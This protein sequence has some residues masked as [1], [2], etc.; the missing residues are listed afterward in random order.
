MS[1]KLAASIIPGNVDAPFSKRL[2]GIFL[3][4]I[5]T[6]IYGGLL[7]NPGSSI[8]HYCGMRRDILDALKKAK[9]S[10]V[11]L[12]GGDY[13]D[14]Y[15]W[16]NGI[17]EKR[18]VTWNANWRM[19]DPNRFGTH[20]FMALCEYLGAEPYFV[21]NLG[22]GTVE[23]ARAWVEYCNHPSGTVYSEMRIK[24]GHEKPFGVKLWGVGNEP[25]NR[26]GFMTPEYYASVYRNHA[27]FMRL[28]DPTVE[29][30]M[31]GSF[32]VPRGWNEKAL[33]I[34]CKEWRPAVPD[35]IQPEHIS[36]H[37]YWA[38]VPTPEYS[39][40]DY[41][42]VLHGLE[43]CRE[44]LRKHVDVCAQYAKPGTK[45][46]LSIDEYAAWHAAASEP[47]CTTPISMLDG[48]VAARMLQ[49]VAMMGDAVSMMCVSVTINTILSMI[50]TKGDD[51]SLTPVY[52]AYLMMSEHIGGEIYALDSVSELPMT[53]NN[54]DVAFV[55]SCVTKHEDR[56]V[57]SL[58]N[59][60]LEKDV[61][62]TIDLNGIIESTAASG[63]LTRLEANDVH[64]ENKPG[65]PEKVTPSS[66]NISLLE[67]K[68]TITV[69]KHSICTLV[70][71]Q[72]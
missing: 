69:K 66:E 63:R 65:E 46:R 58:V 38:G 17:G 42:E 2:F 67:E 6:C 35:T 24:N 27:Y 53:G 5:G 8:P 36:L 9:I 7:A 25:F 62:I 23:E 41:Y 39:D 52:Y 64:D 48:I 43:W 29:L 68:V 13:A 57:I 37:A 61:D 28:Q 45:I 18:P 20:E 55:T 56:V 1:A 71:K 31:G 16:Q 19:N 12:P 15:H 60:S 50:M 21:T 40:R 3:E 54:Q 33:E 26:G 32:N 10:V 49:Y 51:M 59:A 70:L 4:S 30:V 72:A 34:I 22:S 14:N 11:R 47:A 44:R